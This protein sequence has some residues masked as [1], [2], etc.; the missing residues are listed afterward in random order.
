MK[1]TQLHK[2]VK[3]KTGKAGKKISKIEKLRR[4][5]RKIYNKLPKWVKDVIGKEDM[6]YAINSVTHSIYTGQNVIP[7]SGQKVTARQIFINSAKSISRHMGVG[8]K[9]DIFAKFRNLEPSVY[10]KYNSYM[11]RNGFSAS[12]YFYENVKIKKDRSN[13]VATLIL[14]KAKAGRFT[15]SELQI[16]YSYSPKSA[17]EEIQAFM[18][19]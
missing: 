9:R 5:I 16:N 10:S 12:Q 13:I 6:P 17:E 2:R 19:F 7:E 14:P 15:Y 3:K 4:Q 18:Y 8:T 1:N 11:Y